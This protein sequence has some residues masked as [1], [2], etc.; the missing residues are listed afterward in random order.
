MPKCEKPSFRVHLFAV[1]LFLLALA[2]IFTGIF[3]HQGA[4]PQT[5]PYPNTELE[6]VTWNLQWFPGKDDE[7]RTRRIQQIRQA[8]EEIDS[9]IYLF[10]EME[11][12]ESVEKLFEGVDGYEIH[13]VSQFRY[14]NF[15]AKQQLAI[16][17]RFPAKSAFAES[18]VS[19]GGS[20]GTPTGIR[21]CHFGYRREA[22]APRLYLSS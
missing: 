17:S 1:A 2:F 6:I 4:N 11:D 12:G 5:T 16:V 21:L 7:T 18:F 14:G 3:Y 9:D 19:T 20:P 15:P 22:S 13:I 10:Q 8:V